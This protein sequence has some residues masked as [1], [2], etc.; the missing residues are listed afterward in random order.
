MTESAIPWQNFH[1][2]GADLGGRYFPHAVMY[3]L[4]TLPGLEDLQG[5]FQFDLGA[6]T[7]MLYA[8]AFT[9]EQKASLMRFQQRERHAIIN[10]K[11]APLLDLP[12]RVGPWQI[13]PVAWYRDF[14]DEDTLPDGK[15]VLGTIGADFVRKHILAVDFPGQRLAR[16][17]CLPAS[18]EKAAH[19]TSL[20][21]T[22]QG[23][24]VIEVEV[25][26]HP[27]QAMFDTG[28]SIFE[29][30][31]D[32]S[33][34]LQ[35]SKGNVTHTLSITA[36]GETKKISGGSLKAQVRLGGMALPLQTVHYNEE[37][38]WR[39]FFSH[40]DVV[41]IIGNAPFLEHAIVLDFPSGR[42]GVLP[43][44]SGRA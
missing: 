21:L 2:Q 31:T 4:A 3:L 7:T 6:P 12:L 44:V 36:W 16:L 17:E 24:I 38:M 28:S 39:D 25:D 11:E 15:P 9:A 29:L 30:L 32:A 35:L 26:G 37:E 33:Q 34:W 10:G 18:W 43:P 23:H 19:W 40:Y 27:R 42:F 5:W 20:R 41:G 22:D 8:E 14:G 1:W 13:T